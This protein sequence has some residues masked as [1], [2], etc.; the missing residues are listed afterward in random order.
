MHFDSSVAPTTQVITVDCPILQI[1]LLHFVDN[2][3]PRVSN[4]Y[5]RVCSLRTTK[6]GN[7]IHVCTRHSL[8]ALIPNHNYM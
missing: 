5:Q 6:I 8:I 2:S 1:F 3:I 4:L 7:I